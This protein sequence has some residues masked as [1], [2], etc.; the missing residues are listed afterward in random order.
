MS[1]K[2][3][4]SISGARRYSAE[5]YQDGLAAARDRTFVPP[6]HLPQPDLTRILTQTLT[7]AVTLILNS[8]RNSKPN[9][10]PY[11][12]ALTAM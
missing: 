8:N 5:L 7:L 9:P 11:R 2:F 12:L 3:N 6:E 10:E 4:E 1:T